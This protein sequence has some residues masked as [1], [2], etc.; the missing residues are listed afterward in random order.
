MLLMRFRKRWLA[1]INQ[2]FTN[3]I[4]S[5]FAGRLPGF[6][7]VT[8]IGRKSGRAY[9]T[10]V[11]VFA[12]ANGFSIALT[13]GQQSEWVKNVIAAGGC[14]LESRGKNYQLSQPTIVH[15]PNR[16]RFPFPARTILGIV[17]ANDVMQL[18][19]AEKV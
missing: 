7:I 4:T 9:R 15:D 17:G 16:R 11:N 18:R 10:P 14:Q 19:V 3:R 2:V 12:D 8:H 5:H 1:K 13:Y 6:G